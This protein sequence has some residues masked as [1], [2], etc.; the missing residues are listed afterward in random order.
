MEFKID[1]L[2][3]KK[4]FE[5]LISVDKLFEPSLSSTL[6]LYLYSEKLATHAKFLVCYV[7]S[8]I[9]GFIAFY[10]NNIAKQYYIPLICVGSGYQCQGIGRR[11][12]ESLEANAP[13]SITSIGLEVNKAN[14]IAFQFY[15]RM[16]FRI[17]EDRGA[18]YLMVKDI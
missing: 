3:Q 17:A 16:G 7:N 12:L 6:D 2:I 10:T 9:V 11:L 1:S 8:Q 18:K 14:L 5:I 15:M 4:I 13:I